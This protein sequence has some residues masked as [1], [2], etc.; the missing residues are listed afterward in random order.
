MVETGRV[1]NGGDKPF[2][3]VINAENFHALEMLTYTHRGKIDAI[4]IDPPYNTG[5]RDWKYN[6]DYVEGDD[7][8]RHSKW[9][10]FMERR[11]LVAKELLNPDDSVLIVTIDEK[12]YLRLGLLLE[13]TF[14]EARIQMLA[15]TINPRAGVARPDAFTRVEEYVY[16][17]QFGGSSPAIAGL[18]GD[19]ADDS[20]PAPI[21]FSLMRTGSNSS[22]QARPNL[23]YPVWVDQGGR[24]AAVGETI[25]IDVDRETVAPPAPGLSPV[26]PIRPNGD[27]NTWQVG[28][29]TLRRAFADG[30]ARLSI[31]REKVTVNYLRNAEK[32]RIELGEID[33]LGKDKDGALML[34]HAAGAVRRTQAKTLWNSPGHDAGLY[35]SSYIRD[36]LQGRRFPFPKSLYLV[37]DTLRFFVLNKRDAVVLD[38]FSGSGTTAHAVMRLNHQDGGRRQCISVTN[39]EVSA[40]EQSKLRKQGL[41]PGD[42]EWEQWGICDYITKPRIRAAITGRTPGGEPIKGDYKFTDEFPMADGF[43]E[44]AAFFTLT[45]ETPLSIRHNRAFERIAPML[46]L[47]AGS[48]GRIINDLGDR[49]WDVS[50]VYAVLEDIDSSDAFLEAVRGAETVRTVFVVTDN[51]AAFQMVCRELPSELHVIQLYESYLQ[52][53]E[54]NQGRGF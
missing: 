37:E 29:S 42:F 26:W 12:E 18:A 32:R 38:F 23:F 47:R 54:I 52:N 41:R 10:A 36:F 49:G 44:N 45:Y 17:A 22:R 33:V 20:K 31:G 21:W 46:W 5:A 25:P 1:E 24:L 2:H 8:Y 39:N 7:H 27:E 50:D 48:I 40:D 15:A 28:A 43:A 19:A 51:D 4:Y 6:N 34:R 3:T 13:Q 14:P 30:T 16:V 11:L 35:G 9:L 53:F